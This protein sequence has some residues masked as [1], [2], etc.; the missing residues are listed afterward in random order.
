MVVLNRPPDRNSRLLRFLR[1]LLRRLLDRTAF[2]LARRL[3]KRARD[4][5]DDSTNL[6]DAHRIA[7]QITRY[8]VRDQIELVIVGT[9]RSCVRL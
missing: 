3:L 6:F 5:R 9:A 1:R 7:A 8:N 2:E 4:A